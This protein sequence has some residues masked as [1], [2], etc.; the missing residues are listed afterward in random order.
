[1]RK[2][3]RI[4]LGLLGLALLAAFAVP[5]GLELVRSAQ[6]PATPARDFV[7]VGQVT[8]LQRLWPTSRC[9]IT[10]ELVQWSSLGSGFT[11]ADLPQAGERYVMYADAPACGCL[12]PETSLNQAFRAVQSSEGRWYLELYRPAAACQ[13]VTSHE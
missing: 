4:L 5:Y 7:G 11:L 6:R 12:T 2:R 13:E 8:H 10:L 1:M 9:R 3:T